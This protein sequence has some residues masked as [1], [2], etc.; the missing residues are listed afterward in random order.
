MHSSIC[1]SDSDEDD[2]LPSLSD[3]D[4]VQE[5]GHNAEFARIPKFPGSD[6]E[7]LAQI[8]HKRKDRGTKTVSGRKRRDSMVFSSEDDSEHTDSENLRRALPVRRKSDLVHGDHSDD[9]KRQIPQLFPEVSVTRE[10]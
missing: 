4:P 8:G 10:V 6:S 3:D 9:K 1:T 2:E 5:C 7:S